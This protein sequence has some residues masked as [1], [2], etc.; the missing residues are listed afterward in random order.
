[1]DADFVAPRLRFFP[2]TALRES[3]YP[4]RTLL[5]A[6]RFLDSACAGATGGRWMPSC[7]PASVAPRSVRGSSTCKD[8]LAVQLGAMIYFLP[9]AIALIV[10]VI[11]HEEA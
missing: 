8:P 6:R 10:A 2:R 4:V 5:Q 1:M 11:H 7:S 3:G 9:C